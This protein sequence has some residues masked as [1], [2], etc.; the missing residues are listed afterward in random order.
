MARALKK[1]EREC[2]TFRFEDRKTRSNAFSE[3][4]FRVSNDTPP[5]PTASTF[6]MSGK[7]MRFYTKTHRHYCSIDLHARS[8]YC[9]S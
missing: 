6:G 8:M 9:A 2:T 4:F 5:F 7:E 1:R 3:A